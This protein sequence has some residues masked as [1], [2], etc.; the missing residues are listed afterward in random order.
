MARIVCAS[1]SLRDIRQ[2][3][4]SIVP[5][6][7]TSS[8]VLRDRSYWRSQHVVGRVLA[9][10]EGVKSIVGWIGPCIAVETPGLEFLGWVRVRERAVAFRLPK[11]TQANNI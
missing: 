11:S 2:R 1:P 6:F 8:I 4:Y 9:G 5:A 3:I 7:A 10:L